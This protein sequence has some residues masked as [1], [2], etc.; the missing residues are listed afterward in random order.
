V[1]IANLS[2]AFVETAGP[3]SFWEALEQWGHLWM[4]DNMKMTGDVTWLQDAIAA[5][6]CYAVTDGSYMR[7]VFPDINA[8]AFVIECNQGRG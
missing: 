4:W 3:A 1:N 6:T 5:E 8:V 7:E 2:L